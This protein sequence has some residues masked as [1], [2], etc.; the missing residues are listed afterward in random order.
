MSFLILEKVGDL[1]F[2]G[3]IKMSTGII[4]TI[5]FFT[6]LFLI[7]IT[8]IGIFIW[9]V[10]RK[11][12][13]CTERG[14]EYDI[15]GSYELKSD[16]LNNCVPKQ[17]NTNVEEKKNDDDFVE[18]TYNKWVCTSDYRCVKSDQ[19]YD[20]YNECMNDCTPRYYY[21]P[22]SLY[23]YPQRPGYWSRRNRPFRSPFRHPRHRNRR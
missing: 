6:I 1:I 23:Y 14:C 15:N 13:S 5:I 17:T 8:G 10:T 21:Y 16:C 11:R 3:L 9:N 18:D 12:W 19:G 7:S 2:K 4:I 20:T 22:Q